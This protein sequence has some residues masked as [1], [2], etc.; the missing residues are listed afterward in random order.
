MENCKTD[1]NE[2][3]GHLFLTNRIKIFPKSG[4]VLS[5]VFSNLYDFIILNKTLIYK[6]L[7]YKLVSLIQVFHQSNYIYTAKTVQQ[8]FNHPLSVLINLRLASL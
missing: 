4:F 2:D 5:F 8:I 7:T 3:L 6:I 1:C